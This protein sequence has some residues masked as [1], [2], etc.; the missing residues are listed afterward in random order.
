MIER[1]KIRRASKK[2]SEWAYENVNIM[3]RDLFGILT[4]ARG[5]STRKRHYIGKEKA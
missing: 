3:L 4:P 2:N 1:S 5:H